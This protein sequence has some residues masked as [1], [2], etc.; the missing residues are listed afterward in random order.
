MAFEFLDL[1]N[2]IST[3]P[4]SAANGASVSGLKKLSHWLPPEPIHPLRDGHRL[5]AEKLAELLRPLL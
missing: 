4:T 2:M 3:M 5:A 1:T